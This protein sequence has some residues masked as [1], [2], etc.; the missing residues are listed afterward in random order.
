VSDLDD[1]KAK[2]ELMRELGV[3]EC[4]G[5]KLGPPKA[6]K[7]EPETLEQYNKRAAEEA[8]RRHEIMFAATSTRPKLRVL[9]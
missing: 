6:A 1:L 5:I 2:I 4:D 3:T 8:R 7:P 9:K